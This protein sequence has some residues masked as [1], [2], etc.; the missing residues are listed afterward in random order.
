VTFRSVLAFENLLLLMAVIFGLQ[1]VDRSFGPILPLYVGQLGV[2]TARVPLVSGVLFSLTAVS[3]AA[4][5][6]ACAWLLKRYTARAVIAGASV[7]GAV[8]ALAFV[9]L[10]H[11]WG[12]ALA[13]VAFGLGLGTAMTAAYTAAGTVIP[14]EM[15]GTGF[16]FL[17][18]ASLVG[19]AVSPVA[20]GLL[21]A[22]SITAV[23]LAD[24][25]ALLLVGIVVWRLMAMRGG[26]PQQ[27][28]AEEI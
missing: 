18:T 12:L 3:G 21:G 1:V 10:P 7:T 4:G 15:R 17:T 14:H 26:E 6:Q 22:V 20:S 27:P 2:S 28:A 8:A 24:A 11:P 23:F 9:L 16:G 19:L 5:N 25:V 13:S